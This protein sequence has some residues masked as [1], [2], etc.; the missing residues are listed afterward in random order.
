MGKTTLKS[1]KKKIFKS[2][3]DSS[4]KVYFACIAEFALYFK[5]RKNREFCTYYTYVYGR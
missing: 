1:R 5:E 4:L 3:K 2:Q